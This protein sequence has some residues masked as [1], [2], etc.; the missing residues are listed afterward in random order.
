MSGYQQHGFDP[1]AHEEPGPPLRP[2]NWVQWTGVAIAGVGMA[3]FAIYLAGRVGW[4]PQ[5]IEGLSPALWVLMLVGAILVNS[6]RQPGT[7]LAPELASARRRSLIITAAICAAILGVAA[8]VE[9]Q[10]A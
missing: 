1:N 8:V 3:L 9:L 7:D 5:W 10:G 2:Y 4:I 6:R